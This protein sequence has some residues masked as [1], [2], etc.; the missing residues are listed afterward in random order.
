[1]LNAYDLTPE[2]RH[3]IS[4]VR[5]LT[6]SAQAAFWAWFERVEHMLSSYSHDDMLSILFHFERRANGGVP[7]WK[8]RLML[9]APV[10][11]AAAS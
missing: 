3:M 4:V 1:M 11:L 10:N 2:D 9:S 7:E 6:P 5:A 8:H